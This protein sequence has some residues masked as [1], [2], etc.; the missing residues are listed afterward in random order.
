MESQC[1]PI[2]LETSIIDH[3]FAT[4]DLK[5]CSLVRRSWREPSQRLLFAS[6]RMPL[7]PAPTSPDPAQPHILSVDA[8]PVHLLHSV[9]QILWEGPELLEHEQARACAVAQRCTNLRALDFN[10]RDKH[11]YRQGEAMPRLLQ[12][13]ELFAGHAITHLH[14]RDALFMRCAELG[15]ALLAF[16]AL[17]D[18]ALQNV[19]LHTLWDSYDVD[20]DPEQLPPYPR[21]LYALHLSY[22]SLLLLPRLVAR[23][24]LL[25]LRR[26]E[27]A[28]GVGDAQN[29]C[30]VD[31]AML[32][33]LP[34]LEDVRFLVRT[35]DRYAS[36]S[37]QGTHTHSACLHVCT[38][39]VASATGL[40]SRATLSR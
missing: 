35:R 32:S 24:W 16:P 10:L 2:E 11:L 40:S 18:L 30:W 9:R 15:D 1:L 33:L 28:L 23:S 3:V 21:E 38:Q 37:S 26:L 4:Q 6:W 31:P 20:D 29:G 17:V 7:P 39:R 25:G 36:G 22:Q 5:A 27:L 34:V 14:L 19:T 8:V 13:A 12:V